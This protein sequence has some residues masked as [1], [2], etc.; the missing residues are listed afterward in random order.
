[1]AGDSDSGCH[2]KHYVELSRSPQAF[3]ISS[4]ESKSGRSLESGNREWTWHSAQLVLGA[5]L[6]SAASVM[7]GAGKPFRQLCGCSLGA[8]RAGSRQKPGDPGWR[9]WGWDWVGAEVE[10]MYAS[11]GQGGV[12]YLWSRFRI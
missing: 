2:E 11:G 3:G 4:R 7:L 9:R 12:A 10:T 8:G 5:Q 6:K 1:M